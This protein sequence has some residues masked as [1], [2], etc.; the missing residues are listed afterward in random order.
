MSDRAPEYITLDT[1]SP[2]ESLA[3]LHAAEA[4]LPQRTERLQHA[5]VHGW[6][7]PPVARSIFVA[8]VGTRYILVRVPPYC[9]WMRWGVLGSGGSGVTLTTAVDTTG[10][11]LFWSIASTEAAQWVL[12]SAETGTVA[13]FAARALEMLATEAAEWTTVLVRLYLFVG[14]AGIGLRG[15]VFYPVLSLT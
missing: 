11:S 10:T 14:G 15:I 8:D 1:V 7:G 12:G 5:L 4:A 6:G 13:D 2:V 9:R 3:D